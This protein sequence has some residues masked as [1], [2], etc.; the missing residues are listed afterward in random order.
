MPLLVA[1]DA[2]GRDGASQV[3]LWKPVVLSPSDCV[4]FPFLFCNGALDAGQLSRL[5]VRE[6]TFLLPRRF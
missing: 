2:G 6:E 3:A 5:L 4:F 1:L